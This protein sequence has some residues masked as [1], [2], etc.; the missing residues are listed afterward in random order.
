VF[1]F[2]SV[3]YR[4][5]AQQFF[6]TLVRKFPPPSFFPRCEFPSLPPSVSKTFSFYVSACDSLSLTF[7]GSSELLVTT[8]LL[9]PS[10]RLPFVNVSSP[11][12]LLFPSIGM[13]FFVPPDLYF[14]SP[15]YSQNSPFFFAPLL[16]HFSR[17]LNLFESST[18]GFF[19]TNAI[20]YVLWQIA[21][22]FFSC[23]K[24]R[25]SLTFTFP[26]LG[27]CP[28][29]SSL[30][31]RPAH[32]N[33]LDFHT[34]LSFGRSS[35]PGI[36]RGVFF[37]RRA[38]GQHLFSFPS[39]GSRGNF[40]ICPSTNLVVCAG[41]SLKGRLREL[42]LPAMDLSLAPAT[43]SVILGLLCLPQRTSKLTCW[44]LSLF[45]RPMRSGFFFPCTARF[46]P[47]A[48]APFFWHIAAFCTKNP[49]CRR[50]QTSLSDQ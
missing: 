32:T 37:L 6:L 26:E 16:G 46:F 18:G 31:F 28:S 41:P 8:L 35:T 14:Y 34:C 44:A 50:R 39:S 49:S 19:Q 29:F 22:T 47:L 21:F 42:P 30:R 10:S 20:W 11:R 25:S 48:N 4:L 17:T 33:F 13:I 7:Q 3:G 5:S 23:P 9:R 15:A 40:R 27:F 36:R 43:L 24:G 12:I 2:Q 45:S 38:G 1:S